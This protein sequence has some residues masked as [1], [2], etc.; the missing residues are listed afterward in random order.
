MLPAHDSLRY[1]DIWHSL[2]HWKKNFGRIGYKKMNNKILGFYASVKMLEQ[3]DVFRHFF[4]SLSKERQQKIDVIKAKGARRSSLGA[5]T[6]MDY[7]LQQL[8]GMRQ[9]DVTIAYGAHGKPY[10]KDRPE[11]RFNLS[12]SG[13][14]VLAVF[15]PVELGCDIQMI[16]EAH[17]NDR[18]AARFF[19]EA[20]Q[21]ALAEGA[22]FYR[23]WVRKESY[24]KCMGDG[25]ACDLRSFDVVGDRVKERETDA[26]AEAGNIHDTNIYFSDHDLLG[27]TMAVCYNNS[28]KIPVSWQEVNFDRSL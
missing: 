23:I 21:R 16:G 1:N 12:H 24:I 8:Y 28:S 5:W 4:C 17:R 2:K 15:G 19:T 25:M 18:I 20:E 9:K 22:D 26:I 6:L 3:E 7:G 13:D 14:Y 11:I 27:Y 10:L